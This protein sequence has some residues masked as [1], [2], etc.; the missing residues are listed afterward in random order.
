MARLPDR[1]DAIERR[2]PP[3]SDIDLSGVPTE[4]LDILARLNETR[5][6]PLIE[7]VFTPEQVKIWKEA[8]GR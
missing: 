7:E 6:L 5:P 8:T 1:L 2:N 4:M 3:A